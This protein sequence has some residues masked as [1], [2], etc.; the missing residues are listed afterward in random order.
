[1]R[2]FD[3]GKGCRTDRTGP[4]REWLGGCIGEKL[5]TGVRRGIDQMLSRIFQVLLWAQLA[6]NSPGLMGII[7]FDHG[8]HGLG[9]CEVLERVPPV[10]GR[11]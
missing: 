5:G 11:R 6:T 4:G 2:A 3:E 8:F 9:F 7:V 10:G 1:M